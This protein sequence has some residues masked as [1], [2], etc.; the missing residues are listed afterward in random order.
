MA[1]LNA[2]MAV[3]RNPWV[4]K[5]NGKFYAFDDKIVWILKEMQNWCSSTRSVTANETFK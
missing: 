1:D 2:K 4:L 3:R 5:F